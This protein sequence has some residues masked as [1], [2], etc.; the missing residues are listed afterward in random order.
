MALAKLKWLGFLGLV[1]MLSGCGSNGN[2]P[3]IDLSPLDR[4]NS[5]YTVKDGDTLHAISFRTGISYQNLAKWNGVSPPYRIYV[6]DVLDLRA[7]AAPKQ[8]TAT[9]TAPVRRTQPAAPTLASKPLP[10]AKLPAN[11]S[12]W[13][14]PAKGKLTKTFSR[15]NAQYGIEIKGNRSSA[16]VSTAAGQVVYA[17]NGIKG[18]GEL[19]IVK[20]SPRYIS[21]YA[22]NDRI[23]VR[24]GDRVKAGQQLA[25]MGSTGTRGVK[26]HFEIRKDGEP[27]NPLQYLPLQ[28]G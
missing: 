28:S 25:N 24:E 2:V 21:A 18:Y 3:V 1:F 5:Q 16:V 10:A 27:V 8:P 9:K 19:V 6:G 14:W 20:H 12:N 17:G 4:R 23:L 15:K 7:S 11:V 22:Y 13:Q 26:L